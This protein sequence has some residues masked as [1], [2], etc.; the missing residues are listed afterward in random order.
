MCLFLCLSR[1]LLIADSAE[2]A[3]GLKVQKPNKYP[4]FVVPVKRIELLTFGLQN[5]CSTAELN[6]LRR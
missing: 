6:R 5:R 1:P 2:L 3:A 4:V